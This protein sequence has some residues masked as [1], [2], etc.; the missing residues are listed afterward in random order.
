MK[1]RA[2]IL[3]VF[4]LLLLAT[5]C[6]KN[7]QLRVAP[8][9]HVAVGRSASLIAYEETHQSNNSQLDEI[10]KPIAA[11]W[12]VSDA[13][14]ASVGS[15]GTLK[16]LKPGYVTIKTAWAGQE[17]SMPVELV[18]RLTVGWLPQLSSDKLHSSI[19]EIKTSLA[20]DRTLRFHAAFDDSH[21]DL[22]LELKAPQQQLPWEFQF[23]RGSLA[24]TSA[25]G[26]TVS[27]ELHLKD[28]GAASFTVWSDDDG[29]YPVS[30]KGKTV[31]LLGDSM[32]Q[33]L[34]EF[35]RKKIEA[36]GAHYILESARSSTI[37]NW[38]G[39]RLKEVIDQRKPD[40]LF[41]SLGSNELFLKNSERT[42]APL[43]KQLTRDLGNLPAY[44]I[45]PPSWKPDFGL[46]RTIE[47]NFQPYH[48]YNSNDLKV[49]RRSDE[50]HPTPAGFE[51]W[52]N[53]IWNWYARTG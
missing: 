41:I 21:D 50:I 5:A 39:G 3:I 13:S 34:G 35:L 47:A 10:Q 4:A 9:T 20:A 25:A 23:E 29:A 52:A 30:L 14:I 36:A 38:Q 22:T 16:G 28:R 33:G 49:P 26:R 24:L 2:A 37:G 45:G 6:H 8:I 42:R 7:G 12:T 43:I 19:R 32:A 51:T 1:H 15:E 40:V 53:L 18:E 46:V 11:T 31:V 48:F 27:G 17:I 44:W